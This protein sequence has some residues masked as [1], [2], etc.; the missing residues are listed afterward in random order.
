MKFAH[1]ETRIPPVVVVALSAL[2]M[3]LLAIWLPAAHFDL[4]GRPPVTYALL[5]L[6]I[7]IAAS[8][9]AEFR[10]VKTT[11]DPTRPEA[12]T[13]MVTRGIYKRTRNPMYLGFA[14]MLLAWGVYLSNVASLAV[15]VGFVAYITRFQIV[16]E[17]RVLESKF[18]QSFRNYRA[19]TRRWI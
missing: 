9:V 12:A 17:E 10:R 8:G 4:R 5:A 7:A 15:I 6:G 3:W 1:L 2:A 13:E 19:K 14:F 18:G 16:P 11:V